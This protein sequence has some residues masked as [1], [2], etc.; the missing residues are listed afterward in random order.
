[1]N[2]VHLKILKVTYSNG[3]LTCFCI[4]ITMNPNCIQDGHTKTHCYIIIWHIY[5]TKS[6]YAAKK[7]KSHSQV[8]THQVQHWYTR[9]VEAHFKQSLPSADE[10]IACMAQAAT[11]I[12]LVRALTDL[13]VKNILERVMEEGGEE[14]KWRNNR[15][16][17]WDPSDIYHCVCV[18]ARVRIF[19]FIKARFGIQASACQ[20]LNPSMYLR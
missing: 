8:L 17:G 4:I 3:T 15:E 2:L 5:N 10:S 12:C 7:K 18:C 19:L 11:F 14:K 9:E 16:G 20:C 1:M 13:S 6:D